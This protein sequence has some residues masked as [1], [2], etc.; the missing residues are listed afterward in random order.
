[1]LGKLYTAQFK[2]PIKSLWKWRCLILFW[3]V[4]I[5]HGYRS[6]FQLKPLKNNID[7]VKVFH[8]VCHKELFE[9]LGKLNLFG[10]DNTTQKHLSPVPLMKRPRR[11]YRHTTWRKNMMFTQ[12]SKKRNFIL[13]QKQ[14]ERSVQTLRQSCLF[15]RSKWPS[16]RGGNH[17]GYLGKSWPPN[18]TTFVFLSPG[19]ILI[20]L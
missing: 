5:V 10:K 3:S 14:P 8:K 2:S 12:G 9:L 13:N 20:F 18:P 6:C 17:K 4:V 15:R 7:Y 19:F 11:N 1:M 16:R